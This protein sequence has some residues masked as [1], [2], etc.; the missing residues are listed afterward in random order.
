MKK[1]NL[2]HRLASAALLL[3]TGLFM[4]TCD[5]ND[6]VNVPDNWVTVSTETMSIGYEG[7]TLLRDYTLANGL[8]GKVVYIVNEADWCSGYIKEDGKIA[9]D[10]EASEDVHGRS[11]TMQL[12]YDNNHQVELSVEQGKA[13]VVSVTG[14][15]CENLPSTINM[16]ELLDL[17]T[18]IS[19]L[20][21]NASFKQIT[22]EL[23][24]DNGIIELNGSVVKGLYYGTARVKITAT[25]DNEVAGNGISDMITIKVKGDILYDRSE[26]TVTTPYAYAVDGSTGKPEDMFD[27][28]TTTFLSMAK[29]G[30]TGNTGG[31]TP[32]F[33]INLQKETTFNYFYLAHRSNNTTNGLRVRAVKL[34]GSAD[35]NE[36]TLIDQVTIDT[37]NNQ[38]YFITE[39]TCQYLK[40]EYAEWNTTQSNNIQISEFKLG[41]LIE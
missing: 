19:V 29:P 15:N 38:N 13:P 31:I 18:V 24:D 35:G 39:A 41:R 28:S 9:I 12:I 21:A 2:I 6:A 33:T 22:Y 25:D 17:N 16:D 1:I 34:Y 23:V 20:P 30:K 4:A 27:G 11:A 10:V 36:F 14:F 32:S 26:W 40:V 5:D 8:D 7:G 37:G 3:S